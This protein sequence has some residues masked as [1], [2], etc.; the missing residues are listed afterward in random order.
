[1]TRNAQSV[2]PGQ[3]QDAWL[4]EQA[5]RWARLDPEIYPF[6]HGAA[7]DVGVHDDREQF[8]AGLELMLEGIRT[9]RV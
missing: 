2:V 6:L 7:D 8:L 9:S 1:M 3:S 5:Q 4:A